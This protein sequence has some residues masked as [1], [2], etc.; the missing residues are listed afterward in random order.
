MQW[1]R[2]AGHY[3]TVAGV[4]AAK[5]DRDVNGQL[6]VQRL[7]VVDARD[8]KWRQRRLKSGA[9]F[10]SAGCQHRISD[11]VDGGESA[12]RSASAK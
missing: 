4:D 1:T 12:N 3:V 6:V 8:E 7:T 10:D 9:Q 2:V 11:S 5:A